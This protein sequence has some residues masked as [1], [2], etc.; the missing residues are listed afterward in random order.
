MSVTE[1]A[2]VAAIS[3]RVVDFPFEERNTY[4]LSGQFFA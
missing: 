1:D 3:V 4:M 2:L